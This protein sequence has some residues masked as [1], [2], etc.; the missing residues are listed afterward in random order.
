[1]TLLLSPAK[2]GEITVRSEDTHAC[3][4]EFPILKNIRRSRMILN[5]RKFLAI[6]LLAGVAGSAQ[7]GCYEGYSVC[8]RYE[9][10]KLVDATFCAVV[11]CSNM[12]NTFELWRMPEN[13]DTWKDGIDFEYNYIEEGKRGTVNGEPGTVIWSSDPKKLPAFVKKHDECY[14]TIKNKNVVFCRDDFLNALIRASPHS[15]NFCN[16][17]C[18]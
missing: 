14:R 16:L 8:H 17:V 10:G 15:L 3:R 6:S 5:I 4:V 1:M 9:D 2:N 18:N 7:A 13:S 12:F 11:A